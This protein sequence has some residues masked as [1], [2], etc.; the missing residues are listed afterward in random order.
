MFCYVK[1]V[2][3][4]II[5][6]VFPLTHALNNTQAKTGLFHLAW[7]VFT[8]ALLGYW[9]AEDFLISVIIKTKNLPLCQIS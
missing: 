3:T 8:F 4:F 2:Y 5:Q 6:H 1:Y 9:K 7:R